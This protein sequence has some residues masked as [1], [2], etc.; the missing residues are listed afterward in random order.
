MTAPR[1]LP[2]WPERLA[3][4][5][6]ASAHRPFCWGS[7]DCV[8]FAAGAVAAV[9]GWNPPRPPWD[10]VHDALRQLRRVGGL[11]AAV[12]SIGLQPL[13]RPACA[14]RGDVVLIGGDKVRRPFLGVCVGHVWAAPGERGLAYGPMSAAVRGW[15][16]G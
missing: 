8:T 4:Y 1:R 11:V 15:K 3:G 9:T 12:E 13:S 14:A 5:I 10:D 2:G 7:N 6:A 16:V